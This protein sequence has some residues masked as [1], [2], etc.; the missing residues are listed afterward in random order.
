MDFFSYVKNTISVAVPV[1]LIAGGVVYILGYG[2]ISAGL[3]IGIA[4]GIV[5]SFLMSYTVV[6]GSGPVKAFLL[7][8]CIIGIVFV[9]GILVSMHAFFAAVAGVLF[10]HVLFISDQVRASRTGEVG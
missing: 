1:G 10:V 8:Y 9:G 6:T 4:G 3:F 5:K 2:D 7:R